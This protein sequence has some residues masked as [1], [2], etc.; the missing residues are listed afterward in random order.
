MLSD[1]EGHTAFKGR[2]GGIV[3]GDAERLLPL[4]P[5]VFEV[6]VALSNEA[7]HGYA[8]LKVL[9]GRGT[10]I[11]ASVL[12]RKLHRLMEEGLVDEADAPASETSEDA[13]RRY[14]ALTELGAEVARAEA[15]RIVSLARSGPVRSLA[16]AAR[17]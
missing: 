11:A 7:L 16:R 12:Y 17:T 9:E 2:T 8:I 10:R 13:R 15:A 14:Y 6:L 4:K 5:E 3:N 1:G